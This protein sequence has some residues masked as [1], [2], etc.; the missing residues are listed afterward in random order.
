LPYFPQGYDIVI[1]A[2]RDASNLDFWEISEELG[3][4][5]SENA[6]PS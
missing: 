6:F 2:K 5:L 1:A 4:V 3:E